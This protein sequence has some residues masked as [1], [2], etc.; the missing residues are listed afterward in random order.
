MALSTP[1]SAD[2]TVSFDTTWISGLPR[3]VEISPGGLTFPAGQSNVY[4][5]VTVLIPYSETSLGEADGLISMTLESADLLYDSDS[6]LPGAVTP[7]TIDLHAE[8]ADSPT[9]CIKSCDLL[10]KFDFEF[11]ADSAANTPVKTPYEV[12]FGQV[13]LV[14]NS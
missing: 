7:P 9:V 6:T 8:D 10:T 5:T 12:A 3:D 2:V 14:S 13:R 4:Q 1:P 11:D